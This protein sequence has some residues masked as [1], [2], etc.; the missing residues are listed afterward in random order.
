MNKSIVQAPTLPRRLC[1]TATNSG[2]LLGPELGHVKIARRWAV[3]A[4]R[5]RPNLAEPV[6]IAVSEMTTNA[7]RHSASG[8]PGGSI[9][10]EIERTPRHLELRVT[11]NGPRPGE[12]PSFPAVPDP[13][14]LRVGGNG[15][16]LVEALC[17]YWD[18]KQH[19]CGAIT[20]RAVF[21]W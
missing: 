2:I 5:S 21:P 10:V 6:G 17:S 1:G 14:P 18:W 7:L 15:L 12:Q 8:L 3:Q 19:S 13:E 4:T 9:R 16:R 11:D 20:V